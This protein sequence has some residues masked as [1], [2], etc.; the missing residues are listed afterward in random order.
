MISFLCACALP[1]FAISFV[2]TAGVRRLA[3]R[4]GLIDH[5]NRERKVHTTPTPL[6]GGIGIWAGV[7]VT[8]CA[9]QAVLIC[10]ARSD[11]PPLW[12]PA[13]LDLTGALQR[14]KQLWA[15]VGAGTV[16][17]VMGLIDD[18]RNLPW[19]P[20]LMIQLA[21]AI[22]IVMTGVRASVFVPLPWIGSVITVVWI[23][24]LVNSL[25]FLDNMDGLSPGIGLV[26]SLMLAIVLLTAT[27]EPRW[28]AGGVMLV[29]AGSIAGFLCFNWPPASIFM[30]DSGSYFIGMLLACFTITGTFY[31]NSESRHVILAPLCIL[32]VPLYDF[33]SVM[34]IRLKEGR[35]PF[36][37]D[38]SHFSHRLVELGLKPRNAVLTIH[39]ATMTTGL[40]ALLLYRVDDWSGA[41]IVVALILCVLAIIAILE[42][43]GRRSSS[44]ES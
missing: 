11:V 35:S 33:C 37:A 27:G 8:L 4:W 17:G 36:H 1:A 29:L 42:T 21:V 28:L 26:A 44:S 32:A 34:I 12:I 20:R 7:V 2:V 31:D 16:L 5:P 13:A 30:G 43:V 24:V 23:L 14:S 22:G 10:A 9:A 41:L 19:A 39:L 15:I 6:G 25:N 40:G 18:K 3:P 38:K